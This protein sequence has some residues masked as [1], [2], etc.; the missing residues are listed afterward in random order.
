M[1]VKEYTQFI[2]YVPFAKSKQYANT[3][4]FLI[5]IW[6]SK[7]TKFPI[8]KQGDGITAQNIVKTII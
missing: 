8:L 1:Y 6:R 5:L 7:N 4:E 2:M 3:K